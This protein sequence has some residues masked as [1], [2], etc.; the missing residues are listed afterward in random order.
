MAIQSAAASAS[1]PAA[2]RC[3]SSSGALRRRRPARMPGSS[4]TSSAGRAARSANATPAGSAGSIRQRPTPSSARAI[5]AAGP[6][7]SVQLATSAPSTAA[8]SGAS[9]SG[10]TARRPPP[11]RIT[12]AVGRSRPSGWSPV[13]WRRF[14]DGC[15]HRASAPA[16]RS[17]SRIASSVPHGHAEHDGGP[18]TC[19]RSRMD[20]RDRAM[21][22]L[23]VSAFNAGLHKQTTGAAMTGTTYTLT[24]I[25]V[26][27]TALAA[28][29]VLRLLLL[30]HGRAGRRALRRRRRGHAGDQPQGH[31]RR[32]SWPSSSCPR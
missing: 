17:P 2:R 31:Q 26:L 11:A 29:V 20:V 25:A 10:A 1:R 30:H 12:S 9:M 15:T 13:R 7:S 28:G 4:A 8:S 23:A 32:C 6:S 19:G 24:L 27:G 14:T 18:A 21:E 5:A 3:S 16:R 22:R